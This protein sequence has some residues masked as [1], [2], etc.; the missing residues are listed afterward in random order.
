ML[1]IGK[2]AVST[3]MLT[4][5]LTS[6]L[7]AVLNSQ[8]FIVSAEE[9]HDVAITGVVPDK[10]TVVIPDYLR[11][12]VYCTNRGTEYESPILTVFLDSPNHPY[13]WFNF[14]LAP[15]IPCQ[16]I[17]DLFC[18][19]YD[20]GTWNLVA[21]LSIVPGETN[22]S[23]NVYI[24]G[25]ITVT[26]ESPPPAETHDVAVTNVV[27]SQTHI[28]VG[29]SLP[30]N[31]SVR[32][33]GTQAE[34]FSV[35]AYFGS[36]WIGFDTETVTLDAGETRTL[37]MVWDTTGVVP[38]SYQIGA[39]AS[40]VPG[41]TNLANNDYQDGIVVIVGLPYA[42]RNLTANPVLQPFAIQLYWEPPESRADQVE[43]YLVY[44]GTS[45]GQE[46]F[47]ISTDSIANGYLDFV[48]GKGIYY[49]Y[50]RALYPEGASI[51]S[52]IIACAPKE[53]FNGIESIVHFESISVDYDFT[54]QQNVKIVLGD[55]WGWWVQNV[56]WVS[57][58]SLYMGGMIQVFEIKDGSIGGGGLVPS[59]F[60][61]YPHYYPAVP[62]APG[63]FSNT[64]ALRV[65]IEGDTVK[66]FNPYFREGSKQSFDLKLPVPTAFLSVWQSSTGPLEF[67]VSPE[68]VLVN[69]PWDQ[70]LGVDAHFRAGTKGRSESYLRVSTPAGD[71]WYS[72]DNNKIIKHDDYMS[73]TEKSIGLHWAASGSFVYDSA[74]ESPSNAEQGL[75]LLTK[76][77]TP[78]GDVPSVTP[79]ILFT[80][81]SMYTLCPV[82]INIYDQSGN[83]LGYNP[84]T[85]RLE[86]QILSSKCLSNQS[87]IIA[88]PI[89]TY[90][91][92]VIGIDNGNFTLIILWQD[93][94][95]DISTLC[96]STETITKGVAKSWV[97][98]PTIGGSYTVSPIASLSTS[99]SP[100]SSSLTLGSSLTFTSTVSGG[101][102]PYSFQWYLNGAPVSGA[103]LNTW[104][105][106]PATSG[107]YYVSLK[108]TDAV[109][110]TKQSET[111]RITVTTV[112]VGGYSFSIQVTTKAEP[113][114]P[115]IALIAALT[116]VFTK[117]RPKTKRKR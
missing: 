46:T 69:N 59:P 2:K 39:Y 116:A 11:V 37:N 71:I 10:T 103:T 106:T 14:T 58:A 3:I 107:I 7:M 105:F 40:Q 34:T 100:L 85:G 38:N 16:V 43:R 51:P 49:Y 4:L 88:N 110:N 42:P 74:Y 109:G 21:S 114:I 64:V 6:I 25:P 82:Y 86:E 81:L 101:I 108:V 67:N 78:V 57:K 20:L 80:G 83:R 111:A 47:L 33:L 56:I 41:E 91:L 102:S 113:I 60:A 9:I 44:R 45:P 87:L 30:V 15:G 55:G 96:N 19:L 36:G 94:S 18:G 26:L 5:L 63:V 84:S 23:D 29:D 99:I 73:T 53:S 92:S 8:M 27:A 28:T 115:Y 54:V 35:T 31:V 48:E 68:L 62:F 13:D 65:T 76:Y 89:E 95:G 22:T 112:P 117:L 1:F 50:V 32:N 90:R 70:K 52:N 12:S 77:E 72:C 66:I 17:L 93:E 98:S 97:L 79:A 24:Y 75:R 61:W 104:A